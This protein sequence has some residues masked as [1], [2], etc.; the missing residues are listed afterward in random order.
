MRKAYLNLIAPKSWYPAIL[1]VFYEGARRKEWSHIPTERMENFFKTVELIMSDQLRH[2]VQNSL[3]DFLDLYNPLLMPIRAQ[4]SKYLSFTVKLVLN[5]QAMEFEPP[6][7]DLKSTIES[8][9]DSLLVAADRVPKIE[10]QLFTN[11]QN[12]TGGNRALL[13]NAKAEYCIDVLFE[14]T[15]PKLV[16]SAREKLRENLQLLLEKP[17]EYLSSFEKIKSLIDKSAYA[18]VD[19]FLAT[20]PPIDKMIEVRYFTTNPLN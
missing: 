4:E 14:A 20:E 16:L 1:N 10:T 15:F 9:L 8:I 11:G 6:L 3:A 18:E 5:E 12:I 19:E 2:I 13:L 17:K 7:A